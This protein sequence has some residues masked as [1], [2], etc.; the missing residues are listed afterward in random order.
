MTVSQKK[1]GHVSTS[2]DFIS[3]S[4][5]SLNFLTL[6]MSFLREKAEATNVDLQ[7]SLIQKKDDLVQRVILWCLPGWAKTTQTSSCT[8]I[9]NLLISPFLSGHAALFIFLLLAV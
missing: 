3:V 7:E 1:Q 2:G 6:L 4:Y 8:H 5:F 9:G